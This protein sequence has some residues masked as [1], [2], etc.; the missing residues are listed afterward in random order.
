M[1]FCISVPDET[2]SFCL[3]I[4]LYVLQ[5]AIQSVSLQS[6]SQVYDQ[7][8]AQAQAQD[9]TAWVAPVGLELPSHSRRASPGGPGLN[10]VDGA[11]HVK[12][13]CVAHRNLLPS[14]GRRLVCR[15]DSRPG[16]L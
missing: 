10:F 9:Q 2:C 1:A 11:W 14:H 6:V 15:L 8:Q 5:S 4:C 12:H 13:V 7:A 16:L 3:P